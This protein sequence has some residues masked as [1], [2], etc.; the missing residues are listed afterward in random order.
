MTEL[1][2]EDFGIL[3]I[4][5]PVKYVKNK[6]T[7]K[8]GRSFECLQES[9]E[10][11]LPINNNSSPIFW[12][13]RW[14]W[15][16][17]WPELNVNAPEI[18]INIPREENSYISEK[19]NAKQENKDTLLATIDDKLFTPL[20]GFLEENFSTE[21]SIDESIVDLMNEYYRRLLIYKRHYGE[22]K[23]LLLEA[24]VKRCIEK[25]AE[26]REWFAPDKFPSPGSFLYKEHKCVFEK[27]G[28]GNIIFNHIRHQ[29]EIDALYEFAEDSRCIPVIFEISCSSGGGKYKLKRRLVQSVYKASLYCCNIRATPDKGRIGTYFGQ[30]RKPRATRIVFVSSL[31]L[32]DAANR[33]YERIRSK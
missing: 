28:N 22:Y 27:S 2:C 17:P 18:V 19:L 6:G 12:N 30:G 4:C 31:A 24:C 29:T 16:L 33:L 21:K 9:K 32:D 1:Q 8:S 15:S 10:K 3:K 7:P 26:T 20:S 11:L 14:I 23:G 5:E 13:H 25:F